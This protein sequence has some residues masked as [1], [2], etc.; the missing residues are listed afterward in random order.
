[1]SILRGSEKA[2]VV[3]SVLASFGY[4][5]STSIAVTAPCPGDCDGDGGVRIGELILMVR[6]AL[7][8]DEVADCPAGDSNGDGSIGIGDLLAA[9][10]SVLDGCKPAFDGFD[11][12]DVERLSADELDGRDNDT[13]GSLLAQNY[14]LDEIRDFTVGLDTSRSGDDSYRQVF[15]GGTNILALI[16]G[17]DLS[18]EYVFVGGH[19]DHFAGCNGVCN[20]ATDNAAGAAIVIAIGR[21]LAALPD[22]PRR[23]VVLAFWDRE[24]DG[25]R[26]SRHYTQNPLVPLAD[27]VAYLNFDIQG[28]NL[29]PSLRNF[30]FAVGAETGGESFVRLV[31]DAIA[32]TTLDTR[33]LSSIF[34]QARSDYIHFIN[35]RVPTVFFSDS[36]GPCYH[37]AD[38]DVDAVDFGKLEMQARI[39]FELAREVI[40]DSGRPEFAMSPL[41]VFEDAQQILDVINTSIAADIDRF[42]VEDQANLRQ[43]QSDLSAIVDDGKANFDG[44]DI[45]VLLS[46]VVNVID[47][48]TEL[49]CDGFLAF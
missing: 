43:Y 34:G 19:Y 29:L 36:T 17:G 22:P 11:R 27:T 42:P 49:P 28:A 37:T 20:G 6:I 23:S 9:V 38:D 32:T 12:R 4:F 18:D 45:G 30:S 35:S 33:L 1:M 26:G 39:G 15:E 46:G 41:S 3:M 31:R 13:P 2:L 8:N 40:E 44:D 5:L 14:I 21:G 25:L 16:P 48:L 10:R 7:G 47:L 24:E